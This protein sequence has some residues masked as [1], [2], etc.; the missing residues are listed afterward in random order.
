MIPEHT[1]IDASLLDKTPTLKLIQCDA[2][3]DYVDLDA[4]KKKGVFA[5]NA[6]DVNKFVVAE[7]TFALL[8]TLAKKDRIFKSINEKWRMKTHGRYCNRIE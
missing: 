5:S 8:L 2:G 6:A 4:D 7:H 1:P 3:Y